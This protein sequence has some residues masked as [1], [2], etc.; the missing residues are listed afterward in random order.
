MIRAS[1]HRQPL[2]DGSNGYRPPLHALRMDE[3]E[4][5][6]DD[7]V[8]EALRAMEVRLVAIDL[9]APGAPSRA[10]WATRLSE[11]RRRLPGRIARTTLV[12]HW[13]VVELTPTPEETALS[14]PSIGAARWPEEATVGRQ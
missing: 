12:D 9:D 1:F 6:P 14:V 8:V 3:F 10:D 13:F 5:F 4:R 2:V 11:A 7:D